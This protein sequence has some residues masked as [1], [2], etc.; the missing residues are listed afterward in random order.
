MDTPPRLKVY[1]RLQGSNGSPQRVP[2]VAPPENGEPPVPLSVV[3]PNC[4]ERM[5]FQVPAPAAAVKRRRTAF[6]M[7]TVG[8]IVFC[9]GLTVADL[10]CGR[11]DTAPTWASVAFPLCS[12]AGLL[13]AGNG[14]FYA[15]RFKTV[16]PARG[17]GLWLHRARLDR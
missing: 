13:L 6:A 3:C 9:A 4:R 8:I 17:L 7:T 5:E 12:G 14:A 1:C 11:F 15:L 2:A 16:W 10:H